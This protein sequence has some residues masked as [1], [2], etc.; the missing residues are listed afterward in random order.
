[1]RDNAQIIPMMCTRMKTNIPSPCLQPT[2]WPTTKAQVLEIAN[3]WMDESLVNL[4]RSKILD[5]GDVGSIQPDSLSVEQLRP[6]TPLANAS[7]FAIAMNS[8]NYMFWHVQDGQ[9]IRYQ[10]EGVVGALAMTQ[11]FASAWEDPESPI[12][13]AR[14]HGRVLSVQDIQSVFGDI[15]DPESRASI[16]NE[17]FA[18][19]KLS[20][21]VALTQGI[22]DDPSGSF[23]TALAAGIAST[24]PQAY[25]DEVLKKAQLAVSMVWREATTRGSAS[26]CSLTAFAD[27]QIPNVLRAMGVLEYDPQLAARIDRGEIIEVGSPGEK[28]IRAASIVAVEEIAQTHGV[29]VADVDYWIWLKRKE[30]TTPFHLSVTTLY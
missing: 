30:P 29:Q 7:A 13:Q 28:A 9:F 21:V 20:H 22:A 16:L 25:G 5:L 3:G 2:P 12:A 19:G 1:M 8:I 10:R 15:P 26:A 6:T 14:D 17:V 24:F 11:A 23:D 27:Y 4:N 18:P